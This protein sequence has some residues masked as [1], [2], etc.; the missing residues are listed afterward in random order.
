MLPEL[1]CPDILA[2]TS[3][4]ASTLPSNTTRILSTLSI[5]ALVRPS[6]VRTEI[7]PKLGDFRGKECACCDGPNAYGRVDVGVDV[8]GEGCARS[9]R[10]SFY[11]TFDV[12]VEQILLA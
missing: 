11:G 3:N 7:Q 1:T 9:Y 10:F 6:L 5:F 2:T 12:R 4:L 8:D